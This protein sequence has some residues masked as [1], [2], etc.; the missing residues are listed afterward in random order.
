MDWNEGKGISVF[1]VLC[2]R[3]CFWG[4]PEKAVESFVELWVE[5]CLWLLYSQS[6]GV[7]FLVEALDTYVMDTNIFQTAG[8]DPWEEWFERAS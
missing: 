8:A 1:M 7:E 2:G 5:N 3:T 6:W 4:A